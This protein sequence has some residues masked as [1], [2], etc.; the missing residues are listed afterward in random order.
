[1]RVI[2]D[3]LKIDPCV[4][5]FGTPPPPTRL[6]PD[7]APA[8]FGAGAIHDCRPGSGMTEERLD[9]VLPESEGAGEPG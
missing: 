6:G 7:V 9:P 2:S 5:F 8:L 4:G 3:A 1:M